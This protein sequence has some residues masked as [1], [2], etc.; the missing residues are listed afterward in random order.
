MKKS[1]ALLTGVFIVFS[2][3]AQPGE[4][5]NK[6]YHGTVEVGTAVVNGLM[7][8]DF[9]SKNNIG[10]SSLPLSYKSI[11]DLNVSEIQEIIKEYTRE[12]QQPDEIIR[13]ATVHGY[14][15]GKGVFIGGGVGYNFARNSGAKYA[16]LFA[17][18]KYNMNA[19]DVS[20]YIDT[21]VGHNFY[22]ENENDLGGMF[23]SVS[24]GIDYNRFS[25]QLGYEYCPLKQGNS[26]KNN[27]RSEYKLSYYIMNQFFFSLAFNF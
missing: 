4:V 1:I 10:A 25:L 16:S 18:A 22:K 2:G 5:L 24:G 19:N 26:T 8:R 11:N 23:I 21:R 17:D 15:W 14:S 27:G 13:L 7:Q 9:Q 3:Y 6:G 12:T 20:P